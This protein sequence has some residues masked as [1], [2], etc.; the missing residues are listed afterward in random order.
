M[1]DY[2]MKPSPSNDE[3]QPASNEFDLP[4]DIDEYYN[5]REDL[6]SPLKKRMRSFVQE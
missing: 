1:I 6:S 3:N 4:D 2:F 5:I